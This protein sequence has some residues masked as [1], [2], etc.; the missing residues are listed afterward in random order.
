MPAF[1]VTSKIRIERSLEE[2]QQVILD[3]NTWPNWSPWLLLE[4]DA[5]LSYYGE[6]ASLGH[7]YRWEGR[8]VG[9]G[10]M[11]W[12]HIEPGHLK[13][14]LKFLKP[15]KSEADV[16][17]KLSEVDGHTEV[18]WLMDSSLPFF[19]FFMVGTMKNMITLDYKRGLHLLKDYLEAGSVPLKMKA[20]GI[21]NA[22]NVS[23]LGVSKTATMDSIADSM[24][25]AFEEV[26]QSIRAIN[27]TPV[28]PALSVYKTMN[29]RTGKCEYTAALPVGI[30]DSEPNTPGTG[31]GA[32]VSGQ[33]S[34]GKAYKVVHTGPYRHLGNAWAMAMSDV[35]HLK[36]KTS[37]REKPFEIYIN[38]PATTPENELITEIYVPVR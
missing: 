35:R 24:P 20:N 32:L 12:T 18:E 13:A 16:G 25:A 31:A 3:F 14:K 34:A 37:R 28:G 1:H 29:M 4:P 26:K 33:L 30:E 27:V 10:D 19:M 38:G 36:M 2:T 22:P 6:V 21:V 8:K 11:S 15:F 17:F 5:D 9:S 23:Y 7:G